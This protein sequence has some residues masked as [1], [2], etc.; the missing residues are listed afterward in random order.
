[1]QIAA[2]IAMVLFIGICSVVGIRLL[3]LAYRTRGVEE[4]LCA[5]GFTFIG[6]LGYPASIA[7]GYG[8]G[9][10]GDVIFPAYLWGTIWTNLG[11]WS[12]YAFTWRVFRPAE[13]WALGFTLAAGV[14]LA[15]GCIANIVTLLTSP[16]N[17]SSFEVTHGWTRLLQ[18]GS[19]SCF[20]WTTWE[21]ARQYFMSHKR[22]AIGLGDSV[23]SNRFLL[24]GVFGGS[25]LILS[26]VFA[27]I[28]HLGIPSAT[29]PMMHVTTAVMGLISSVAIYLAFLPP[30][31]Y[32]ARLG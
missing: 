10:V 21:A 13:R 16:A 5:C 23:S 24:W 25:T 6:L 19:V 29:S 20:A 26:G 22:R 12:F 1:M 30:K 4:L 14:V 3:V 31:A 2:G 11:I 32:L 9:T 18:V 7:S 17:A 15:T 28:H 8:M 27:V